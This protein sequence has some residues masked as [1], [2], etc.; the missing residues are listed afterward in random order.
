MAQDMAQDT[1]PVVDMDR[2]VDM[3]PVVDMAQGMVVATMAHTNTPT[4]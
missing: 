2:A 3:D 4:T 1:D